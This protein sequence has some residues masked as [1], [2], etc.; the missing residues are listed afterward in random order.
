MRDVGS[1]VSS[2]TTR[3]ITCLQCITPCLTGY[4]RLVLEL[5]FRRLSSHYVLFVYLP[6]ALLVTLGGLL[7]W[8]PRGALAERTSY[9]AFLFLAVVVLSAAS[10]Y[11]T[12]QV[13]WAAAAGGRIDPS[14]LA[15]YPNACL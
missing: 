7:F 2:I 3:S 4:D 9:S 10:Q 14:V 12:P 13:R 6:S 5:R 11:A 8:L 1:I 15:N